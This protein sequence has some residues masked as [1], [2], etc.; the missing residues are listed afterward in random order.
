M[1]SNAERVSPPA[2]DDGPQ[3][4]RRIILVVVAVYLLALGGLVGTVIERV[5]FNHH[6]DAVLARYDALL[7]ARNATLMTLERETARGPRTTS[8]EADPVMR[9]D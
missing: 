6:R 4:V 9:Q 3:P 1:D 8:S 7:R 2:C 5:R